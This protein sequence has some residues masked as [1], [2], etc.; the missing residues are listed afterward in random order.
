MRGRVR[1]PQ[2]FYDLQFFLVL[3]IIVLECYLPGSSSTAASKLLEELAFEALLVNDF[4]R[5]RAG[6]QQ[7]DLQQVARQAQVRC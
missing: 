3:S 6:A 7:A 5:L 2:P 1:L 4:G